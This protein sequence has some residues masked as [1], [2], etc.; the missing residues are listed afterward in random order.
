MDEAAADAA[1]CEL[2]LSLFSMAR[3][4]IEH[5]R[6]AWREV[7]PVEFASRYASPILAAV[8]AARA[9]VVAATGVPILLRLGLSRTF[10]S[11]PHYQALAAMVREHAAALVGLDVLGIVGGDDREPMPAALVAIIEQL[12]PD[13]PD[14]TIHA[15]EFAGADSVARTLAL[16]PQAIGHGVRAL[17]DPAVLAQVID[18]G[19]TLEVCPTSNLLLIPSA[20]AALEAA[21]GATPLAALQ[22]AGVRCVLGSD[23]PEPLA[24]SYQRELALA[25]TLGVDLARLAHDTATRWAALAPG[26]APGMLAP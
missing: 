21:H 9:R 2:R 10:E 15:G 12:R 8:I 26:P 1:G 5:E 24:T 22:R 19:V 13:L 11:A 6:R 7:A 20:V 23:D 16:A 3:T 4:L 25:A 17:D 14:L 18:A